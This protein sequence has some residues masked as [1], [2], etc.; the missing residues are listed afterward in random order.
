VARVFHDG[1]RFAVDLS[2]VTVV[3]TCSDC[4]QEAF[5]GPRSR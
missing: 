1:R 5:S 2:H 4:R 3:G